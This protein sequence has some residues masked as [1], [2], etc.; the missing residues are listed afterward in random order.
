MNL[1]NIRGGWGWDHLLAVN[2]LHRGMRSGFVILPQPS[3]GLGGEGWTM[4]MVI[5][6]SPMVE[7]FK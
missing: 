3:Y 1:C 6:P 7:P 2:I 4:K 5:L